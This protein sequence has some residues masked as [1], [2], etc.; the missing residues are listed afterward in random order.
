MAKGRRSGGQEWGKFTAG[1][2]EDHG[3]S[4]K[5]LIDEQRADTRIFVAKLYEDFTASAGRSRIERLARDG[6]RAPW[7]SPAD[8]AE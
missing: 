7:P 1:K 5:V 3:T 8:R 6:G 2:A 4:L